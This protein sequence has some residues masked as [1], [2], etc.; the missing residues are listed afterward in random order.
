MH[1]E[2]AKPGDPGGDLKSRVDRLS[3]IGVSFFLVNI[4]PRSEPALV[5]EIAPVLE[6]LRSR[7]D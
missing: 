6:V 3:P 4:W 1:E 2:I 7:T 5:D